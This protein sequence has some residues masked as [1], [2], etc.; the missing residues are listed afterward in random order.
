MYLGGVPTDFPAAA[1]DKL[2]ESYSGRLRGLVI[3]G[4]DFNFETTASVINDLEIGLTVELGS[5][6]DVELEPRVSTLVTPTTLTGGDSPSPSPL[7]S[8]FPPPRCAPSPVIDRTSYY[9][10]GDSGSRLDFVSDNSQIMRRKYASIY[11]VVVYEC[12]G[13]GGIQVR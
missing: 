10:D 13:Q 3:Y 1:G 9:F 2:N 6:I 8:P 7:P 4:N 11:F 5:C 12:M